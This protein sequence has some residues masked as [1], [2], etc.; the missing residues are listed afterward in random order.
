[1]HYESSQYE[2][3]HTAITKKGNKYLRKVLYQ[4]ITPVINNNK[5]FKDFY[6]KKIS[7]GK[8]HMCA[9]GHCVRKL[10]RILFHILTTGELFYSA[11]LV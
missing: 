4:V 7:E 5:V 10:I 2:H 11:K 9:Q 3:R 8:S 1:M 6:D